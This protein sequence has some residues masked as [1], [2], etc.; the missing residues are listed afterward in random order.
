MSASFDNCFVKR[1]TDKALLVNI[2]EID[3]KPIWIPKKGV[4]DDSEVFDARDNRRG[5]LVVEDWLAEKER[6]V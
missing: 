3:T 5:K 1:E 2:P 4:H 6:W